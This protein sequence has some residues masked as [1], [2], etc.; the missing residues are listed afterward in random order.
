MPETRF[1]VRW[2]DDSRSQCYS[3]SSAVT[4]YLRA[5]ADYPLAE[6]L[7][8]TRDALTVASERVRRK[9]GYACSAAAEQL[10]AIEARAAEF[11][12][13]QDARVTIEGFEP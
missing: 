3:P 13:R 1:V 11:A 7:M 12:D 10:A 9:Y 4:T 8:R 5:G 6:F 2:P